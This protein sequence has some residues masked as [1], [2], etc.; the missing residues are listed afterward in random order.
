MDWSSE[1]HVYRERGLCSAGPARSACGGHAPTSLFSAHSRSAA[2]A[3]DPSLRPS[4][5]ECGTCSTEAWIEYL[6]SL[7]SLTQNETEIFQLNY[8]PRQYE[9]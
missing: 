7:E 4:A 8:V 2:V 3:S 6:R 5:Y 1:F 9:Q